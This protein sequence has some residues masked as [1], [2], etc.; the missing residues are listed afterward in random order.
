MNCED[1]ARSVRAFLKEYTDGETSGWPYW[2]PLC[3][4]KKEL[5]V[6]AYDLDRLYRDYQ[7]PQLEET[8]HACHIQKVSSFQMQEGG[9]LRA[10]R[11]IAALLYEKDEDGYIF[12]WYVEAYYFD[13]SRQ[14]LIYV[15]HEGTIA[16]T[17]QE[18]VK[19][20][21]KTISPEYLYDPS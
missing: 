14:W 11:D 4:L 3:R 8:L 17:G 20:A 12:P 19:A 15:S 7:I 18:I 1:I 2:Y 13:A 5:P 6:V 16:F 10:E 9:E 21:K